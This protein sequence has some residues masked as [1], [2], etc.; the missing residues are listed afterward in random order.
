M[1]NVTFIVMVSEAL[2][3]ETLRVSNFGYLDGQP[4]RREPQ[5]RVETRLTPS[6]FYRA[7]S[8]AFSIGAATS[9]GCET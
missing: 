7:R 8:A 6:T 1:A 4:L 5:V 2:A 9:F 3:R